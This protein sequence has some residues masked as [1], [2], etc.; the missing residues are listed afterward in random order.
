MP[1][2]TTNARLTPRLTLRPFKRRDA[3][4]LHE[5]IVASLPDLEPWL[6]WAAAGYSKNVATQFV[7]DS[8]AAWNEGRAYDFAIRGHDEPGY[9]LGNVSV[10]FTSRPNL[11]GEIGYWVRSDVV[12]RGIATEAVARALA[13]SFDE[14]GM[15]RVALRIAVGNVRSERVAAKLGFHHE[16]LL[17]DEVLV[18]RRWMDHTVWGL[19]EQEWRVERER[20]RQRAWM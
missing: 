13:I 9:H 18:G 10:W 3:G 15:H 1:T 20:Y 19:L 5:A 17:R 4:P 6:P 11:V 16:G 12:G 14:L 7:R 2:L 8:V